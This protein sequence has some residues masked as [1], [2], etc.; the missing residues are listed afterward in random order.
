VPV[1]RCASSVFCVLTGSGR[2]TIGYQSFEWCAGDLFTAPSWAVVEHRA[3]Q[4]ADI[5]ELTDEPVL[6]ALGLYRE[7]RVD[8]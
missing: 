7:Q 1:R 6:R 5:F 8:R 3:E 4:G 2:S